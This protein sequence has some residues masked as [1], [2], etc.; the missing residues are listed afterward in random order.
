M[1]TPKPDIHRY[2][3]R[4]LHVRKRN[5]TTAPHRTL[6]MNIDAMSTPA[7]LQVHWSTTVS[8][9]L[10]FHPMLV[11]PH[12]CATKLYGWAGT[13]LGFLAPS[14]PFQCAMLASAAKVE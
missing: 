5:P 10:P 6:A 1:A 11:W 9:P 8:A 14:I 7:S 4:S 3:A 12:I 2:Q 13:C